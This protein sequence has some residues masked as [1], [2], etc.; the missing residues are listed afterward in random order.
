MKEREKI[1]T[2]PRRRGPLEQRV[3]PVPEP[4]QVARE[5]LQQ[6]QGKR[7]GER[8]AGDRIRINTCLVRVRRARLVPQEAVRPEGDAL[9]VDVDLLELD[10]GDSRDGAGAGDLD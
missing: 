4:A 2:P 5:A 6:R 9:G 3:R 10:G 7:R 1:L 8:D